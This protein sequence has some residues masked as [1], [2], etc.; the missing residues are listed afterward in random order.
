MTQIWVVITML[1][2]GIAGVFDKKA[3]ENGNSRSTFLAFHLFNV[4]LACLLMLILPICFGPVKLNA[5]LVLWE[6]LNAVCAML[7]LIVYYHALTKTQASWVLGIT[8]GYPVIGQIL[9]FVVLGEKFSWMALASAA[10]VSIGVATIGYSA[11]QE[12]KAL[13]RRERLV[14]WSCVGFCTLLWGILGIL[15]RQGLFYGP[16]LDGFL[17]VSLWKALFATA[18]IP[19]LMRG[20]TAVDLRNLKMWK[21]SSLAAAFVAAGNVGFLYALPL[22]PTGYVIVVTACYPLIMYVGALLFLGEKLNPLRVLGIVI[23]VAGLVLAEFG[24]PG[25]LAL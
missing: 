9:A 14:L 5:G 11:G 21:W 15:D 16:P 1:G 25:S 23:I 13:S 19:L 6:G 10:T 2:W 8:A 7:A 3:V 20:Q 12:H 4:P 18:V 24:R 17:T 22:L